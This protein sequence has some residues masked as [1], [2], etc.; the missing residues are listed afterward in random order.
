MDYVNFATELDVAI[1]F[2][3][4]TVGKHLDRPLLIDPQ[5]RVQDHPGFGR[6]AR[7]SRLSF[8]CYLLFSSNRVFSRTNSKEFAAGSKT[9][10][11]CVT[12]CSGFRKL[13]GEAK[14]L[15]FLERS[16]VLATVIRVPLAAIR[17]RKGEAFDWTYSCSEHTIGFSSRLKI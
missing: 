2:V 10:S 13:I 12:K 17:N 16:L 14:W 8:L 15:A 4:S 5:E 6:K 7:P 1:R 3:E 9:V 11:G